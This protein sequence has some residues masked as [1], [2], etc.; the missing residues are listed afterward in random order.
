LAE[1]KKRFGSYQ[2]I[3]V[4]LPDKRTT[5]NEG[6]RQLDAELTKTAKVK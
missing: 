1:I 4:E 3:S 5:L 6:I 2:E